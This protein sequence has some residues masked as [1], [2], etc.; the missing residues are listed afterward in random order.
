MKKQLQWLVSSYSLTAVRLPGNFD[1]H[2]LI[3]CGLGMSARKKKE[4][5]GWG[6]LRCGFANGQ[7]FSPMDFLFTQHVG[8]HEIFMDN[9][10]LNLCKESAELQSSQRL[11]VC[12]SV[13]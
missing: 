6:S 11:Y 10:T 7:F 2:I 1:L 9:V 3:T 5:R 4:V 13:N 12:P 8:S